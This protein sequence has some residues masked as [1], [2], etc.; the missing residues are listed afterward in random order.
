[1]N[2]ATR[3]IKEIAEPYGLAAI[4]KLANIMNGPK[5]PHAAQI[6]A[7]KAL[8]DRGFGKPTQQNENRNLNEHRFVARVPE[9]MSDPEWKQ[10]L[11]FKRSQVEPALPKPKPIEPKQPKQPLN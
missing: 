8:L 7:A 11:E 2:K 3:L 9:T 1:L 10:Y 5:V 6:E 4:K